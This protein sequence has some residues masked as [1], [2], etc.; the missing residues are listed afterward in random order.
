MSEALD[1]NTKTI[2]IPLLDEGTDVTR[3]TQAIPLRDDL[4]RVLPTPDY[5]PEDEHWKFPPGSIVRCIEAVKG[6][7][8]VLIASHSVT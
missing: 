2:Y 7:K 3:P 1:F 4:F 6:G 8:P 5:D